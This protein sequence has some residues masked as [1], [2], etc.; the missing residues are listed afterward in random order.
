MDVQS[1]GSIGGVS[2]YQFTIARYSSNTKFDGFHEE[3]YPT[4]DGGNLSSMD[5]EIGVVW[6]T[7]SNDTEITWLMR[8]KIVDYRYTTNKMT[9]IVYQSTE[10]DSRP[11]PHYTVQQDF[12]NEV[13]YFTNAPEENYGVTLPLIYGSWNTYRD[14]Q[15][16]FYPLLFPVICVDKHKLK[17]IC[18]THKFET[19]NFNTGGGTASFF[20]KYLS[21]IDTYMTI[22]CD[23]GGSSNGDMISFLN[24][25]DTLN[26]SD[27]V[28]SGTINIVPT[29]PGAVNDISDYSNLA[30]LDNSNEI[31]ITSE[32]EVALVIDGNESDFGILSRAANS[33]II[34]VVQSDSVTADASSDTGIFYWNPEFNSGTGGYNGLEIYGWN[35]GD[36]DKT[37]SRDMSSAFANARDIND[38]PWRPEELFNLEYIIRAK[39]GYTNKY[40]LLWLR[41]ANIIVTDARR[42]P[43]GRSR[44][45]TRTR[46]TGG[47]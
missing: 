23:N 41:I 8:G 36:G 39:T 35:T 27:N 7:A 1:S 46:N 19:D 20:Y 3:F 22:S 15:S 18:G 43:I 45:G 25:F 26:S 10:L 17:Y 42:T 14:D 31:T 34:F 30:D 13:S 4:Y 11:L 2:S 9:L 38:E 40:K 29:L 6:N 24:N 16:L 28:L 33:V 32:N 5:C 21:G 12:D 44:T 37:H 47:R